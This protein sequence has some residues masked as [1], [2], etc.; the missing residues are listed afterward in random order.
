MSLFTLNV[1]LRCVSGNAVLLVLFFWGRKAYYELYYWC[2][3]SPADSVYIEAGIENAVHEWKWPLFESFMMSCVFS[4]G[5]WHLVRCCCLFTIR[6]EH[7]DALAVFG[8]CDH[9]L[10]VP[11]NP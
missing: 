10:D 3:N 6:L 2:F 9:L 7:G 5:T 4:D 11:R 1:L 8:C